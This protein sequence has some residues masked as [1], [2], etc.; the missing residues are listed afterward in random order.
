[1]VDAIAASALVLTIGGVVA[2]LALARPARCPNCGDRG[3]S[4]EECELASVP[5]VVAYVERCP[6]CWDVVARRTVGAC[7]D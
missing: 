5:P 1:M 3:V 7:P 4:A 2:L 6:R